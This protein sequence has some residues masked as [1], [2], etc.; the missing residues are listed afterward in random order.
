MSDKIVIE[1]KKRPW[2]EWLLWA[3]WAFVLV[4]IFQ[5]AR[6]SGGELEARAATILWVSFVIWLLAGGVVW[7]TRRN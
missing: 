7:F 1:I 2:F 5:N 6:A 4:F 3:V